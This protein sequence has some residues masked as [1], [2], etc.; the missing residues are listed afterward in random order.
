MGCSGSMRSSHQTVSDC[1]RRRWFPDSQQ[2]RFLTACRQLEKIKFYLPS[3]IQVFHS[4]WYET[5]R[6]ACPLIHPN[7][8][9]VYLGLGLIQ[10]QKRIWWPKNNS[11]ELTDKYPCRV[12]KQQFWMKECDIFRRGGQNILWSLLHFFRGPGPPTPRINAAGTCGC[13]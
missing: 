10:W 7:Y 4:W 1:H 2:S 13:L 3:L 9:S 12:T 11:G 8:F 5:C 6:G